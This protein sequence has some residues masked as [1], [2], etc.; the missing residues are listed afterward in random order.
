[1]LDSYYAGKPIAL[2][3]SRGKRFKVQ[4]QERF[5]IKVD[6]FENFL[7]RKIS[8]LR[9]YVNSVCVMRLGVG[10]PKEPQKI[11]ATVFVDGR[12]Q[13]QP[14]VN[15]MAINKKYKNTNPVF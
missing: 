9:L 14:R 2:R 11:S 10:M 3:Y 15:Q 12:K 4:L 5:Q 7:T 1:M 13:K 8:L 6:E